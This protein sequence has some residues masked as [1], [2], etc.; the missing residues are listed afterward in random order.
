[1]NWRIL[2]AIATL[3]A[4]SANAAIIASWRQ[5]ELFG[6]IIDST[7][8]HPLGIE[9]GAA[10]YGMQGVPNG[11]YGAITINNA[12]GTSIEYG[13][14][15]V[16]EFFTVGTDNIN[17][18]MNLNATG[19]F[20]V[21]G[22]MNPNPLPSVTPRSYKILSTGSVSG[23]DR[24]WGFA[25]R[26]TQIDGTGSSVRFTNFGIA[27]NDSATFNLSFGSWIHLA[28][29]YNNGLITYFLN[30][31]MLD[32]DT[33]AFGNDTAN[34]RLVIGSR[35]GGNDS[36]QMNGLLDGIRVYDQVLTENE[37]RQAATE[38]VSV[39]PEPSA[40][41]LVLAGSVAFMRRRRGW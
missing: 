9:T 25:L 14:I 4:S 5:D 11:S 21:M 27:D 30:G 17:P 33:S 38:S 23:A 8:N 1:M 32:T 34:A 18:V 39:I 13:P 26:L 28:A 3:G 37:I 10:S 2:V 12:A 36:D 41:F 31:V 20:T 35:L 29:T 24:G 16:D 22:W 40:A 19:S 7:G 15:D 6:P